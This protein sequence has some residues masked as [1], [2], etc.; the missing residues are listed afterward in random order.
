MLPFHALDLHFQDLNV[1][2]QP[3]NP[4]KGFVRCSLASV[5]NH[6]TTDP[7]QLVHLIN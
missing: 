4:T 2:I 6:F 5:E 1:L 3:S 7:V